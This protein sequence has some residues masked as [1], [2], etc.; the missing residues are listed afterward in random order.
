M[1]SCHACDEKVKK[2]TE[3]YATNYTDSC[4]RPEKNQNQFTRDN[5]M[6]SAVTS[7]SSV[8]SIKNVIGKC[9]ESVAS[10]A[11]TSTDTCQRSYGL[12]GRRNYI[13]WAKSIYGNK[14]LHR[15]GET[16]ESAKKSQQ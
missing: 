5:R 15:F 9:K 13:P 12:E 2:H 4:Q 3:Y 1:R 16:S 11:R 7:I 8:L 6:I 14:L 10:L